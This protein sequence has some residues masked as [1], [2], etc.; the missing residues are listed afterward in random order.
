MIDLYLDDMEF[1]KVDTTYVD[2]CLYFKSNKDE[3]LKIKANDDMLIDL[4]NKL[5]CHLDSNSLLSSQ[6]GR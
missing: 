1:V 4:Y 2:K 6:K 3:H 5:H